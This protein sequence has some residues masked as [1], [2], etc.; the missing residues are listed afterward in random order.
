MSIVMG[1]DQHRAQITGEWIDTDTGHATVIDTNAAIPGLSR[2]LA[3]IT[4]GEMHRRTHNRHS[5]P[6]AMLNFSGRRFRLSGQHPAKTDHQ[7]R[8]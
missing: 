4:G 7:A 5:P 3:V 8:S 1:L 6:N 2:H